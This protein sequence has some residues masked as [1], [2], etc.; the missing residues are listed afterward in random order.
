M[1]PP[2]SKVWVHGIWIRSNGVGAFIPNRS[3]IVGVGR[4][5]TRIATGEITIGGHLTDLARSL[6]QHIRGGI[7]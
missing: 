5:K 4:Q 1:I 3:G 2:T 7:R 6:Y